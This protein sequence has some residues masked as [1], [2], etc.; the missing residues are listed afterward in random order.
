[1]KSYAIIEP[2]VS[3]ASD[4]SRET[5]P[6][7]YFGGG[8]VYVDV[9]MGVGGRTTIVEDK[10]DRYSARNFFSRIGMNVANETTDWHGQ[11]INER[12]RQGHRQHQTVNVLKGEKTNFPLFL[13]VHV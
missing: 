8:R 6:E 1:M 3:L 5:T 11:C 10:H 7:V 12:D 4:F 2:L 9:M 13:P